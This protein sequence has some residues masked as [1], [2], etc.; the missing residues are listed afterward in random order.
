MAVHPAERRVASAL[1]RQ[2]EVRAYL[3]HRRD[4]PHE[5]FRHD[6]GLK[7]AQPYPLDAGDLPDPLHQVDQNSARL[8]RVKTHGLRPRAV[9]GLSLSGASL[10]SAVL[11]LRAPFQPVGTDV[12]PGEHHLAD[13]LVR[14]G[15]DL[16]EDLRGSSASDPAPCIRDDAVC[17]ELIAPVLYFDKSACVAGIR[18]LH[19]LVCG[20]VR[21]VRHGPPAQRAA[22]QPRSCVRA[23]YSRIRLV[24][25]RLT[26]EL[27][28]KVRYLCLV[29]VADRE[30]NSAVRA[31]PFGICLH[32][33][34]H[35]DHDRVRVPFFGFMDHLTALAVRNVGHR[36]SVDHIY[37]RLFLKRNG[38]I[39]VL[40][41]FLAHNV[42][43]IAVDFAAEIVKCYA[44]QSFSLSKFM[45]NNIDFFRTRT[46]YK[47][48]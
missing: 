27:L 47:S 4:P 13:S 31:D 22:L 28:E 32:V 43:L 5:R 24:P 37:V 16:F 40:F 39:P 29:I 8:K 38:N 6:P 1:Q 18:E 10:F 34:A 23:A 12:D 11:R 35:R 19:I 41:H 42:Q 20:A 36:T 48:T 15:P 3:R 9:P 46:Y 33:A 2:V 14:H 30:I 26:E 21:Q 44:I 25:F 45:D 17:T 7:R